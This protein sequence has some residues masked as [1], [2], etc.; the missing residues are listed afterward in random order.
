MK[1]ARYYRRDGTPYPDLIAWG[2]GLEE[3]S[4]RRV[5]ETTL[6]DGKWVSTVWLGVCLS[7]H[8]IDDAD[9][10]HLIFETMVFPSEEG[11]LHELDQ[12]RYATEAEAI[13]GHNR[14]VEKWTKRGI[15]P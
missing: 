3:D 1:C 2:R 11:P 6:P 12:D 7:F 4:K 14:I 8:G 15:A 10:R 9:D 13:A 5:A